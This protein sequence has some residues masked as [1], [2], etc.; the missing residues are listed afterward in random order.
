[1]KLITTFL[2]WLSVTCHAEQRIAQ[3]HAR[4]GGAY[5][6]NALIG[7]QTEE[8]LIDTGASISAISINLKNKLH[9]TPYKHSHVAVADGRRIRVGVYHVPFMIISG[10]VIKDFEAVALHGNLNILGI[11]AMNKMQPITLWFNQNRMLFGC[12]EF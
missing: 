4:P 2:L 10:C 12:E 1:L 7:S 3:I 8:F 5:A 9:L 6:V 11:S